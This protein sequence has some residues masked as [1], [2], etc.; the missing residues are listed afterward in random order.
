MSYETL[1]KMNEQ[2]EKLVLGPSRAYAG[3]AVDYVEKLT[4]AQLEA[5][6]SYSEAVLAQAR[7]ALDVKD[8]DALKSYVENQQKL[9]Q[10]L[11]ERVKGDTE[12]VVAMNQ[13][14]AEKAQK[15]AQ[16]SARDATQAAQ[17]K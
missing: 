15:L 8:A 13:E 17:A 4:Q 3:L 5:S 10:D 16:D 9:A 11:G 1:N 6:R 2:F 14:F 12:K 7:A